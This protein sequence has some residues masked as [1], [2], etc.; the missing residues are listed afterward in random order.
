[1]WANFSWKR[2]Q[3]V[4]LCP[5][6]HLHWSPR[7]HASLHSSVPVLG[8][9]TCTEHTAHTGIQLLGHSH[10]PSCTYITTS[11][12]SQA[13]SICSHALT[14]TDTLYLLEY[15]YAVCIWCGSFPDMPPCYLD[16]ALSQ[17]QLRSHFASFISRLDLKLFKINCALHPM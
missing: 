15:T 7:L 8:T 9:Y 10:V 2:P 1:M 16:S 17:H 3:A 14:F 13:T 4:Q 5:H 11:P 12:H 6:L